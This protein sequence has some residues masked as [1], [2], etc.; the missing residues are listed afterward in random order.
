[1]FAYL[2]PPVETHFLGFGNTI[3]S[4]NTAAKM[5][6]VIR[7]SAKNPYVRKWAE[8]IVERVVDRDRIGEIEVVYDFVQKS[9]RYAND[10]RGTEYIQTPPY[11]L[12]QIEMGDRPS[13]DCDDYTVLSLSL[14]RSLGYNTKIRIASYRPDKKFTHVYG[15]IEIPGEGWVVFDGVRKDVPLGWEAPKATSIKDFLV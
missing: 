12:T 6:E 4:L 1:M 2:N 11:L 3:I 10:P 15:L 9:T 7:T 13:L 5:R 14:L 8:K